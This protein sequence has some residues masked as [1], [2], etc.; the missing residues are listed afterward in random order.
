MCYLSQLVWLF[1]GAQKC[2]ADE[3]PITE[4]HNSNVVKLVTYILL[5]KYFLEKSIS[6]CVKYQ[7]L[8]DIFMAITI[9]P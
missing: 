8:V 5:V 2:L 6:A 9:F 7:C 3:P 1:S 4:G